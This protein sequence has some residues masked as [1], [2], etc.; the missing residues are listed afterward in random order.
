MNVTNFFSFCCKHAIHLFA[1]I[2]KVTSV[3]YSIAEAI[4]VHLEFKNPLRTSISLS[5][6]SLVCELSARSTGMQ[7]GMPFLVFDL[8]VTSSKLFSLWNLIYA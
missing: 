6:V 4:K 8:L 2:S 5:S 3:I 1:R 7:S